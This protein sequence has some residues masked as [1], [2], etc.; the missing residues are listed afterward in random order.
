VAKEEAKPDLCPRCGT[1]LGNETVCPT[2]GWERDER[3]AAAED[4]RETRHG[5][6]PQAEQSAQD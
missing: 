2:C 4:Q 6:D 3:A 5:Q 1:P